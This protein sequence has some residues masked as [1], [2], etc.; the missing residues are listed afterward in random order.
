MNRQTGWTEHDPRE[1]YD[2]VIARMSAVLSAG[3]PKSGYS[4]SWKTFGAGDVAAIGITN[5][6][7]TT[8]V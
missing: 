3:K 7:E 6:R 2:A 1:I 4:G 8:V 5:Q